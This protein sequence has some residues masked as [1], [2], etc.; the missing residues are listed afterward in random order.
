MGEG[1]F[2]GIDLLPSGL[3]RVEAGLRVASLRR[4][5]KARHAAHACSARAPVVEEET[6]KRG[7]TA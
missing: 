4:E 5:P 6:Q 3:E 7:E 2:L 1:H